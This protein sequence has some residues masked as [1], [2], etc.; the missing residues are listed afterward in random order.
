MIGRTNAGGSG[1]SLNYKLVGGTSQPASPS[2]N[3]VWVN[4]E[5]AIT[6]H[7]FAADQPTGAEGMV[8]IKTGTASGAAMSVTKKN[9]VMVYPLDCK[10][11]VSGA[12]VS[13][14]AMSYLN[15]AWVPWRVY[16]FKAGEGPSTGW[17]NY[18]LHMSANVTDQR[19]AF[20]GGGAGQQYQGAD[21]KRDARLDLTGVST[22]VF[23]LSSLANQYIAC[24]VWATDPTAYGAAFTKAVSTQISGEQTLT[25][26]VS[27]LSG[28]HTV[29]V[30]AEPAQ[31][32][33]AVDVAYIYDIYYS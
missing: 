13:K 28:E 31:Y 33:A 32:T 6:S 20:V 8:W 4:T 18:T 29:G 9:P 10:Q 12:W 7:V 15:G 11:Y 17:A 1:A 26:D 3:T 30:H 23:H 21:V 25:L 14:T 16:L 2:A 22:I 27:E 24:G 19:I 5:T